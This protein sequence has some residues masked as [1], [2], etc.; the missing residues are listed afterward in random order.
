MPLTI[1][2]IAC[3]RMPNAMFRPAQRSEKSPPPSNSVFVD[4][5]R[6]AAPPIIVGTAFL[7][8]CMTCLPASRVATSS[9]AST[10]GSVH[11]P[12]R[13]AHAASQRSRSTG[14]ACD[15]FENACCQ[16]VSSSAPRSIPFM[17]A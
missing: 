15:Q 4:S 13:P 9:P 16:R 3:S 2:P 12:I 6:S 1:E 7:N 5:T 10:S 17:C 11:A 8:A 14:N